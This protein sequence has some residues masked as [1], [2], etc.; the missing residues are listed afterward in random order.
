MTS[1]REN[2]YGRW[3]VRSFKKMDE[4]YFSLDFQPGNESDV[5]CHLYHS[6]LL[7]KEA[8]SLVNQTRYRPTTE[9]SLPG[10]QSK[11]D[12]VLLSGMEPNSQPRLFVEIKETK[13]R[14][15]PVKEIRKRI[16]S[17]YKK[18]EN[19]LILVEDN[20]NAGKISKSVLNWIRKPWMYFFFRG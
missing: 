9:Y 3:L 4:D 2:K 18:L 15:L 10:T 8:D 14:H 11:L 12:I 7:M 1:K 17:D 20:A 13:S 6:L 19:Q 5:K 16:L